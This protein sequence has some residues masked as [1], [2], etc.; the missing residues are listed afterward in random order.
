MYVENVDQILDKILELVA[1]CDLFT[2][3]ICLDLSMSFLGP[4]V[5]WNNFMSLLMS[6]QKDILGDIYIQQH[7]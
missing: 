6:Q 1:T 5:A 3:R 7:H 2:A 4:Y